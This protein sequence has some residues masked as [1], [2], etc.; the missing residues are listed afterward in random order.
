MSGRGDKELAL[1][2]QPSL[3]A[4]DSIQLIFLSSRFAECIVF[5]FLGAEF[6]PT[7]VGRGALALSATAPLIAL[8][9]STECETR[10]L[11]TR[12]EN[13]FGAS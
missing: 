2:I 5:G 1:P 4:D 12:V 8:H 7:L 10:F 3:R 13:I 9:L 6:Y 11:Y